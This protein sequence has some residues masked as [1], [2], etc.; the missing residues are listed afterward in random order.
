MS[1]SHWWPLSQKANK[2]NGVCSVCHATFQLHLRDGTVHRHGPM[3]SPCPGSHKLPLGQSVSAGSSQ[4]IQQSAASVIRNSNASNTRRLHS[5]VLTAVSHLAWQPVE[6]AVI[7]HI[8]KSARAACAGHLAGLLRLTVAHPE[9]ASNWLALLNWSGF[10]LC[11]PKR[12][13]KRNNLTSCIKKR[14]SSY[15]TNTATQKPDVESLPPK[16]KSGPAT[17]QI[18][19]AVT[20]K[21]EEG[22][23]KAAIRL[24]VSD[25]TPALP[26]ADG[27]A[28]LKA[29]HPPASLV[30]SSLP[31]PGSDGLLSVDEADVRRA[32]MS[33]S[34]RNT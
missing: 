31:T 2:S 16:R 8:P 29:K 19:Q 11:A 22:N 15:S 17:V 3:D 18:A 32:L 20:A 1:Q 14:V 33:F 30:A 4:P 26:S 25:D 28:K 23:M 34:A 6:W 21:L 12:G 10:I 9:L 27:L 5:L 24:L 13:G 7:K